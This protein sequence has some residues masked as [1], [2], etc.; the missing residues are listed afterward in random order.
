MANTTANTRQLPRKFFKST[1][2]NVQR[3]V[4]AEVNAFERAHQRRDR[5]HGCISAVIRELL[6]SEGRWLVRPTTMFLSLRMTTPR[7]RKCGGVWEA[8]VVG[9]HHPVDRY[10][11]QPPKPYA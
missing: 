10:D 1:P 3:C 7:T 9:V 4:R 2:S 11:D 6:S 5:K 8:A